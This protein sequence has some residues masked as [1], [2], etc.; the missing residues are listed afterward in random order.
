VSMK[1]TSVERMNHVCKA[2]TKRGIWTDELMA[3][4]KKEKR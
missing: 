2:G 1:R 4:L 3:S